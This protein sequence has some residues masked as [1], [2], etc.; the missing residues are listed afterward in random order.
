MV[1]IDPS[2]VNEE[3]DSIDF[4]SNKVLEYIENLDLAKMI[5]FQWDLWVYTL[6]GKVVM[7]DESFL[8]EKYDDLKLPKDFLKDI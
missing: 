7:V 8:S 4:D 5:K 6:K 1:S 2:G 3:G